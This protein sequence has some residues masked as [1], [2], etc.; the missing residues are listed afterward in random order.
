MAFIVDHG[1]L[2][3]GGADIDAKTVVLFQGDLLLKSRHS[4]INLFP[5]IYKLRK[6]KADDEDRPLLVLPVTAGDRRERAETVR[7]IRD[8]AAQEMTAGYVSSVLSL[9]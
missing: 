3:R 5:V 4:N 6:H 8:K 2:D 1:D 9:R 7:Q